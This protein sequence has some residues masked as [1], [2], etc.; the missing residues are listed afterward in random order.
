MRNNTVA[1]FKLWYLVSLTLIRQTESNQSYL[2]NFK[3]NSYY[4][5]IVLF[6][7]YFRKIIYPDIKVYNL[8]FKNIIYLPVIHFQN[9]ISIMCIFYPY[10]DRIKICDWLI[11]KSTFI[12]IN[13]S[14]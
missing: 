12:P 7:A 13:T 8:S 14:N 2:F 4:L 5:K 3:G 6:N 11:L 1:I 9:R 10:I